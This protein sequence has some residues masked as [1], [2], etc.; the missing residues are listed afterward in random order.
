M[1]SF[2]LVAQAGEIAR[3]LVKEPDNA[4]STAAL[5]ALI[6]PA[7]LR[8]LFELVDGL[9]ARAQRSDTTVARIGLLAL[10]FEVE[11]V[12]NE[13]EGTFRLLRSMRSQADTLSVL[14]AQGPE[15]FKH[16][17]EQFENY[18]EFVKG[19][20]VDG[21]KRS[22]MGPIATSIQVLPNPTPRAP[23]TA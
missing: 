14:Y 22:I 19:V 20:M 5:Q 18:D 16:A 15:A 7:L 10:G 2:N 12:V 17:Y 21:K 23:A 8:E 11:T 1:C 9:R 3:K 4:E 13:W 6:T